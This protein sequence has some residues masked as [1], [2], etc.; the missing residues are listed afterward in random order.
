M[1]NKV[2]VYN[3]GTGIEEKN[4]FEKNKTKN[5]AE[6]VLIDI[7]KI[8]EKLA[9]YGKDALRLLPTTSRKALI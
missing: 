1:A 8:D 3:M 2:Q 9:W 4:S 6:Y 7:W 5:Y